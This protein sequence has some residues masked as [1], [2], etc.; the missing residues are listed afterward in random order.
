VSEEVYVV[1]IDRVV[2]T[3]GVGVAAGLSVP[4][5]ELEAAIARE[6]ASSPLP[7]GRTIRSSVTAS[8]PPTDLAQMVA[9]GVADAVGRGGTRG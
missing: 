2:L 9:R 1:D 8:S 3:A 6:L 5:P 7:P 4:G